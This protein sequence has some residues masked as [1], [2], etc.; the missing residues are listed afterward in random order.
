MAFRP[1]YCAQ[2]RSEAKEVFGAGQRS[3]DKN[4]LRRLTKLD[5]FCKETHRH[6]PSAACEFHYKQVRVRAIFTDAA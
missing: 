6:H 4:T 5:S 1:D 2:M 3:W